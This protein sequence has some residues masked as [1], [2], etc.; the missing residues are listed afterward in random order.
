MSGSFPPAQPCAGTLGDLVVVV[1][2]LASGQDRCWSSSG[3]ATTSGRQG[4]AGP[5]LSTAQ[6][7]SPAS[8]P[9]MPA[10][11][12]L[13]TPVTAAWVQGPLQ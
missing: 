11:P 1:T 12:F 7:L 5:G 10:R 8:Y 13:L 3:L 4:T 9:S 6:L 2:P